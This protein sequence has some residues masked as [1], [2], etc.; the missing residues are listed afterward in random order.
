MGKINIL[1]FASDYIIGLSNTLS[2]QAKS[3]AEL[4]SVNLL[5]IGGDKEQEAGLYKKYESLQIPLLRVKGLDE[6]KEFAKLVKII[7]QVIVENDIQILHIHNNWQLAIASYI[8]VFKNN[9]LKIVYSIHGYRHNNKFKAFFAKIIIGFFLSMFA[10]I[11]FAGST[12]L[13]K[14]LPFIRRKCKLLTQGVEEDLF[15]INAPA[16]VSANKNIVF[17]GQFREGKNQDKLIKSFYNYSQQ[18]GDF[19]YTLY[20]AGKGHLKEACVKLTEKL[21]LTNNVV[22]TGQLTRKE[23]FDLLTSCQLAVISTNFETFGYCIAEPYVAGLCVITKRTGIA[24]DI[25][26]HGKSGLLYDKFS[27]L[28]ELLVNYLPKVDKLTEMAQVSF[29]NRDVLRWSEITKE[30]ELMIKNLLNK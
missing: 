10:D 4:D 26:E 13:K 20:L 28:D 5:C 6:H 25:I 29:K 22:F 24:E 23:M 15:Q 9:K 7:Y 11:V 30:Y 8:K 3:I 14:A 2:D 16:Q 18:T 12:E 27:E 19:N 21:N 17:V 1:Y